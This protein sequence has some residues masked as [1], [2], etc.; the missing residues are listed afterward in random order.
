MRKKTRIKALLTE[1]FKIEAIARNHKI[2]MDLPLP[3]GNDAGPT[4]VD[5]LLASLAGCYGIVSRYH[6]P[7]HSIEIKSMNIIIEAEYDTAGF[8]GEDVKPGLQSINIIVEINSPN[9]EEEIK[10]FMEFVK[11]HCPI[12]DT[13]KSRTPINTVIMKK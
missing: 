4:P 9:S 12:E 3:F 10:R 6:A 7:K 11:K 1:G 13:L 2:I 5:L 8:E